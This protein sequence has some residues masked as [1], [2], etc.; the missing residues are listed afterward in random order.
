MRIADSLPHLYGNKMYKWQKEFFDS[1]RKKAFVCAANQVGKSSAQLRK[2]IDW[3]TN[4]EKWPM[5]W[6]H[7]P[8]MFWYLYP[9]KQTIDQEI[10]TKIIPDLLPRGEFKDSA[11]YGWKIRKDHGHYNQLDFKSG[12]NVYFKTYAQDVQN[13][14][15]GTVDAIFFDE[16]LPFHLYSELN[17]RLIATQGYLSGVFTATMGQEQWRRVFEE[18]GEK[19]LFKGAFKRQITMYD[20]LEYYDGTKSHWTEERI[21]E[22]EKSCS[23]QVEIDRRV[24]GKFVVSEGLKYPTFTREKNV[25]PFHEINFKSGHIYAGVDPGSGGDNHP[26]AICFVWVNAE[27]TKARIFKGWRGDG[28]VTTASDLLDKFRSLKGK[29]SLTAQYYDYICRDFFTIASRIGEP[30]QPADKSRDKGDE[31]INTL[32]KS[33]ALAIFDIPELEPLI[34]ELSTLKQETS[35]KVAVDDFV[36]SMR[37]ALS[38]IPFDWERITKLPVQDD[39]EDVKKEIIIDMRKATPDD[40]YKDTKADLQSEFDFWNDHYDC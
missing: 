12:V 14:Q 39:E 19:E 2:A 21:R 8:K 35:K 7:K 37:Y 16:E 9:D 13:L 17:A 1:T 31:I 11:R 3:G 36:D 24:Y 33:G 30:F 32:F 4:A 18:K 29:L 27:F 22:I 15:S 28:I 23:S 20:C 38:K 25:K 34:S 6:K 5:L 40:F 26:S 10:E